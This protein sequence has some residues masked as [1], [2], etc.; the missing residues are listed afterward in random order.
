MSSPRIRCDSVVGDVIVGVGDAEETVDPSMSFASSSDPTASMRSPRSPLSDDNTNNNSMVHNNS[1]CVVA[2]NKNNNNNENSSRKT[3]T[4]SPNLSGATATTEDRF[5]VE[6]DI[7]EKPANEAEKEAAL[8][9]QSF[10]CAFCCVTFVHKFNVKKLKATWDDARFC[11]YS[12][13]YYCHKC[14]TGETYLPIPARVLQQ[15]DFGCRKVSVPAARFLTSSQW[16][17]VLC[18]SAANPLLFERVPLLRQIQHLR[19]T[20]VVL[21]EIGKSCNRF[22]QLAKLH[23]AVAQCPKYYY[24]TTEMWSMHDLQRMKQPKETAR[25]VQSLE[26]VRGAFMDHVEKDCAV[27]CGSRVM[28]LCA[29]CQDGDKIYVFDTVGVTVCTRCS[30]SYHKACFNKK[31]DG[32]CICQL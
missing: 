31:M 27:G 29:H 24:E 6:K 28:R 25:L 19:H 13:K 4:T 32:A 2:D 8:E 16:T 20:L 11:H 10:Q 21:Y 7:H 23:D 30:R 9:A 14:H 26:D 5:R 12:G 17:P 18:V 22:L 1:I 3:T 15:W